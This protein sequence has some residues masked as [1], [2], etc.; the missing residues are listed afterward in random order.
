MS[1]RSAYAAELHSIDQAASVTRGDAEYDE[2]EFLR[3][4]LE[5]A[6]R[7]LAL[8]GEL[9]SAARSDRHRRFGER[10]TAASL[11]AFAVLK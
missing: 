8:Y 11:R 10:L 5:E 1:Y 9:L 4:E 3:C 7:Q 6:A 2:N